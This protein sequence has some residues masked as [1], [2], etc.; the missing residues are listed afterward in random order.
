MIINEKI[1]P[2]SRVILEETEEERSVSFGDWYGANGNIIARW[3]D[4]NY[5]SNRPF[6][7]W[8]EVKEGE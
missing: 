3:S 8:R 1:R 2:L 4:I 5:G 7:I 6:T